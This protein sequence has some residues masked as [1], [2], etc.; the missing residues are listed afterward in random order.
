M[1][2]SG[3]KDTIGVGTQ[4][5][6]ASVPDSRIDVVLEMEGFIAAVSHWTFEPS[7]AGTR[8]TWAFETE[9]GLNPMMRWMGLFMDGFVGPDYARGL[10]RLHLRPRSTM[11]P[12]SAGNGSRERMAVP[13]WQR[14]RMTACPNGSRGRVH[15]DRREARRDALRT[16]ANHAVGKEGVG[17]G[18]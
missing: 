18:E 3:S 4:R 7:A 13:K 11:R 6:V 1:S 9:L 5:I 17:G 15:N 10:A 16:Q 14:A 2:W 12:F 8:V